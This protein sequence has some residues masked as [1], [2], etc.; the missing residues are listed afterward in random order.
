MDLAAATNVTSAPV[1]G[2]RYWIPVVASA[3][4]CLFSA[5][6]AHGSAPISPRQLLDQ[7]RDEGQRDS[8]DRGGVG[9]FSSE[10]LL[11]RAGP[12]C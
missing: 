10:S 9:G 2:R 6:V 8:I 5:V 1:T 11:L 4:W 3:R 7:E 12:I